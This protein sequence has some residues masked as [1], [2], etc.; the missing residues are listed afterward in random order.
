[1]VE[2]V[3]MPTY[4]TPGEEAAY[5]EGKRIHDLMSS[6]AYRM[7]KRVQE[8]VRAFFAQHYS[9]APIEPARSPGEAPSGGFG[10]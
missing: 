2:P 1:M 9:T 7:D 4:A 3:H 8:E 5:V 10:R 6:P